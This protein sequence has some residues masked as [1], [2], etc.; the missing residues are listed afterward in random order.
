MEKGIKCITNKA[1]AAHHMS[2]LKLTIVKGMMMAGIHNAFAPNC[3]CAS[4]AL[5]YF[6]NVLDVVRQ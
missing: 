3:S 5:T 1:P 2:G 4:G 6:I